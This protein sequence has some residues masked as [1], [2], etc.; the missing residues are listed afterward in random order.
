MASWSPSSW[1]SKP[2]KQQPAY[3][4][5]AR[6]A[7]VVAA[8]SRLPPLV[9]SW[10]VEALRGQLAAAARGDAFLL[11]GGD[12]AESFDDCDSS[13]IAAKLKILL[14]MSLVMIHATRRPVIR[15]G[16]IAGQYA[17]PRSADVETQGELTLPSY[18]GDLVNRAPFRPEDREPDPELLLR[19]YERAALTLNFIRALADG[20]FA[21]LH[22]PEY[23]DLGFAK[24]SANAAAYERM[25]ESVRDSLRFMEAVTGIHVAEM[26]RVDFFTSHE[27]LSLLYE[28]CQTRQVPRR[29]GWYNLSTHY[30]WIGMRTADVGGAHVE[31]FRGIVNPIG[32]KLGP[33]TSPEE[34]IALIDAL[35]PSGIPGRLTLIHRFGADKIEAHLPPLIE[36][37]QRLGSPVL[38][39]AD[40]MH[41]NTESTADGTK[42]RRFDN[43]VA[44][45]ERAFDLHDRMGSRLGGVHLELTGEN[46]TECIGGARGLGEHDLKRDYRTRVDPRLNYEQSLEVAILIAHRLRR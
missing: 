43:I 28:Q 39:V 40:P 16:R 31:Y 10:E 30:P 27:G 41:G 20:G 2:A 8:V 32:V 29:A 9:T 4:D 46:V 44:E 18:R 33:G 37:V 6:V 35:D 22:H 21:D 19:G 42:T 34:L 45:L 5:P 12:C 36:T 15:V 14:Q 17:K 26:K 11:Q 13:A 24:L 23:W 1:Q 25:V 7:A 38:W 3:P